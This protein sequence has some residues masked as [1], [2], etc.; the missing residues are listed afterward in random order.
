[1]CSECCWSI[2]VAFSGT[3]RQVWRKTIRKAWN[4]ELIGAYILYKY[5]P[6]FFGAPPTSTAR[7]L[8]TLGQNAHGLE[9]IPDTVLCRKTP[10]NMATRNL[11]NNFAILLPCGS[12]IKHAQGLFPRWA[13]AKHCEICRYRF[14]NLL[15]NIIKASSHVGPKRNMPNMPALLPLSIYQTCRNRQASLPQKI[16]QICTRSL[17]TLSQG[18]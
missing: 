5:A 14:Q 6:V 17:P 10:D 15:L 9:K 12:K 8:P 7:F 4:N 1:M 18:D 11:Q 16:Y 3:Q 2:K 13:K